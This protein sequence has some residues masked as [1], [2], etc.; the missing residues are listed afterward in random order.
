MASIQ[1]RHTRSC[2]LGRPWT[3]FEEARR[4]CTCGAAGPTYYVVVREGRRLH[5]ERV[6]RDRK[7]AERA[8]RKIGTQVDEGEYRPQ[9]NIRFA[10]WGREWL[11]GLRRPKESTRYSYKS[12]I[13][14]ATE[15]FGDK[16]VRALTIGD[17]SRGGSWMC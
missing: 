1:A 11:A 2:A 9:A 12:T 14:H 17:L 13:A 7:Q 5:R 15:V 8:L 3:T 4:G 6:G 16:V 10:D